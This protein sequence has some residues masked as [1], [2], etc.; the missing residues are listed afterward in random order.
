M[1][2][3]IG[4]MVT[5]LKSPIKIV[6]YLS[7]LFFFKSITPCF[8]S[9][10]TREKFLDVQE[11]N[12]Q[13]K[14]IRLPHVSS[15]PLLI[16]SAAYNSQE[17]AERDRK[18]TFARL[19]PRPKVISRGTLEKGNF[20]IEIDVANGKI[21]E[22]QL[23]QII[24]NTLLGRPALGR[25]ATFPTDKGKLPQVQFWQPRLLLQMLPAEKENEVFTYEPLRELKA[26]ILELKISNKRFE[27]EIARLTAEIL[28]KENLKKTL[29]KNSNRRK[30]AGII[31]YE[32]IEVD[33]PE[34]IY[35]RFSEPK[36]KAP[37][38]QEVVSIRDPD[39]VA[40]PSS[41]IDDFVVVLPK[42]QVSQV[43]SFKPSDNLINTLLLKAINDASTG[44]Y[45]IDDASPAI[46]AY[47]VF[48]DQTKDALSQQLALEQEISSLIDSFQGLNKANAEKSLRARYVQLLRENKELDEYL[49]KYHLSPF[50]VVL[51]K[52]N[53]E[54]SVNFHE[55]PEDFNLQRWREYLMAENP[56]GIWNF[57]NS[58]T[59]GIEA[60]FL[61]GSTLGKSVL[62]IL[63][64]TYW[65]KSSDGSIKV[66]AIPT[67]ME[68]LRKLELEFESFEENALA[69]VVS[70]ST[71]MNGLRSLSLK[72]NV[73]IN[74]LEAL[75]KMK[76]SPLQFLEKLELQEEDVFISPEELVNGLIKFFPP[77]NSLKELE[78]TFIDSF[79]SLDS[80]NL[81]VL[82][83]SV[84][85]AIPGLKTLNFNCPEHVTELTDEA[86]EKVLKDKESHDS[87]S[88]KLNVLPGFV[89]VPSD[90]RAK[91]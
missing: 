18:A 67:N 45:K 90:S 35:E 23:R 39:D 85:R 47:Y 40:G 59:Y 14:R 5:M 24:S 33:L 17:W 41:L 8:S 89:M 13:K 28:V 2:Q 1:F 73:S 43:R 75:F 30:E 91:Q 32:K 74:N 76:S 48:A 15:C 51:K 56:P 69:Q 72:G 61:K 37:L 58:N 60:L 64:C 79:H 52:H 34:K 68:N 12:P 78:I 25:F 16:L 86:I 55:Q 57:M 88:K 26:H 9:N 77:K 11:N 71:A 82:K 62:N 42:P 27:K 83:S 10:T 21:D 38:R 65:T 20:E 4:E 63:K 29:Q 46:Y 44:K 66:T 84:R 53:K 49:E 7:I 3:K 31:D 81:E 19:T 70:L 80:N 54:V 22:T 36:R 50:G 87:Q 6:F